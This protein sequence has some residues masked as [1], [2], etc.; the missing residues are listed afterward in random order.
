MQPAHALFAVSWN[1][2][3]FDS[4]R[5]A[6]FSYVPTGSFSS[7]ASSYR[8]FISTP[9]PSYAVSIPL[10]T[11][12]VACK[13][14]PTSGRTRLAEDRRT[15]SIPPRHTAVGNPS[16]AFSCRS[17]STATCG[18]RTRCPASAYHRPTCAGQAE[19]AVREDRRLAGR[20]VHD[21]ADRYLGPREPVHGRDDSAAFDGDH[22]ITQRDRVPIAL[23]HIGSNPTPALTISSVHTPIIARA[24]G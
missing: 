20:H 3:L 9:F 12:A 5:R 17:R 22:T 14:F 19:Q 6:T 21:A 11:R 16:P 24:D 15:A 8:I 23:A 2:R 1:Q 18:T 4:T 13:G 10:S 7:L